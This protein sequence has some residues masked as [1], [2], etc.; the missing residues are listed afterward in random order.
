V[1][2]RR[3]SVMRPSVVGADEVLHRLAAARRS[4]IECFDRNLPAFALIARAY[5]VALPTLRGDSRAERQCREAL[6]ACFWNTCMF[7]RAEA[8]EARLHLAT[9]RQIE[10]AL[11]WGGNRVAKPDEDGSKVDQYTGRQAFVAN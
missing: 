6:T 5:A 8:G 10:L 3:S 4:S 2:A 9:A 11:P 7:G 1:L